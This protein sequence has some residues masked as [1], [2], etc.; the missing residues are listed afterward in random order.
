[1][2][3]DLFEQ[4]LAKK[5]ADAAASA[6]QRRTR[7]TP[8]RRNILL[9]IKTLDTEAYGALIAD[10]LAEKHK[11]APEAEPRVSRPLVYGTLHRLV[12]AGLIKGTEGQ[13]IVPGARSTIVH[14]LTDKG[15]ELLD[16]NQPSLARAATPARPRRARRK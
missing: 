3:R 11:R 10:Y 9:A 4:L 1:V 6:T 7:L 13:S 12:A 16:A 2:T 15:R 14:K 8:L 5:R